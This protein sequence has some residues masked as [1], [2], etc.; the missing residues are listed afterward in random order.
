MAWGEAGTAWPDDPF[1]RRLLRGRAPWGGP[2]GAPGPP[3]SRRFET[4]SPDDAFGFVRTLFVAADAVLPTA[5]EV[6]MSLL[7]RILRP[8]LPASRRERARLQLLRGEYNHARL[9][10]EGLEDPDSTALYAQALAALVE[11][12]LDEFRCRRAAGEPDEARAALERAR[13]FGATPEQVALARRVWR[14]ADPA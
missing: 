9:D 3:I 7:T 14:G 5:M 11:I 13:R 2:P 6:A 4:A 1:G 10:V 12:N 8:N